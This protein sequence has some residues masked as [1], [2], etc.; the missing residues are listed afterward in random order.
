MVHILLLDIYK[1]LKTKRLSE[2]C[3]KW[4]SET[5]ETISFSVAE[6]FVSINFTLFFKKEGKN[7]IFVFWTFIYLQQSCNKKSQ[8][9]TGQT[10]WACIVRFFN[11]HCEICERTF[12][13]WHLCSR[14]ACFFWKNRK[15]KS[16]TKVKLFRVFPKNMQI[17]S[18]FIQEISVK[19]DLMA[20]CCANT[21]RWR[22]TGSHVRS[23]LEAP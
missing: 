16:V 12:F 10:R 22:R 2:S 3:Q 9:K 4:L 8:R 6:N 13:R 7:R 5:M 11:E 15:R 19:I 18:L 17:A 14:F 20:H 23:A 21:A 1:C